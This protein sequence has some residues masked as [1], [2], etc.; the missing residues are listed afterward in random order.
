MVCK[1]LSNAISVYLLVP[2]GLMIAGWLLLTKGAFS[3]LIIGVP[4]IILALIVNCTL[5]SLNT[6]KLS[7][8]AIIPFLIFF[9]KQSLLGGLDV[10]SRAF[11]KNMRI[12]TTFIYYPFK[13]TNQIARLF[14]ANTV[15]LLPGTLSADLDEDKALIHL[16]DEKLNNME[17]LRMLEVKVAALFGERI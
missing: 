5:P 16:L 14:F 8:P 7:L 17:N 12:S 1:R 13:M 6:F 10:A 3:S 4:A 9:T 11:R 15:S 2:M